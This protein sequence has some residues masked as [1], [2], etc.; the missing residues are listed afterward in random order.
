MLVCAPMPFLHLVNVGSDDIDEL[1]HANKLA[2]L[3]WVQDAAVAHSTAVG[4]SLA[5]YRAAGGVFVVRR[6]EI[7]YLRP[8]LLGDEL[9]V[10]TH[11]TEVNGVTSYRSTEIRRRS[12]ESVT[13]LARAVTL[14]AYFDLVRG[15]PVRI[16]SSVRECFPVEP[17][18]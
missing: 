10:S 16:P 5:Q 13:V 12:G 3:R 9:E 14:W 6:Q 2:Y 8:A 11:L 18:G 4:W 7:D 15:R 17:N 1:G